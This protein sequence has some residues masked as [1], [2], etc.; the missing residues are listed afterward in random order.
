[1]RNEKDLD[2]G[3][4][5]TSGGMEA[6][7]L[8]TFDLEVGKLKPVYK[9]GDV[10]T[11]DVKVT[12]PAKEDPLGNGIPMDRPYVEPAEGVFV[13]VGLMMGRVFLPGAAITGA[14][15]VAHVKIKIQDYAPAGAR[16]DASMYAW[17]IVYEVPCA[18][19]QEYGY[20]SM[21]GIFK[22]AP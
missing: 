1:M 9:I 5:K 22:T 3:V 17:K 13:G 11:V 21:P 4:V 7:A 18:S 8:L 20:T 19:I 6:I 12:R 16:V 2:L 15:G 10:V 14:D